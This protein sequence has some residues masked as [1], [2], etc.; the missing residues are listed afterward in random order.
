MQAKRRTKNKQ[1]Q[2]EMSTWCV[3][4]ALNVNSLDDSF[5]MHFVMRNKSFVYFQ[6]KA[7][8]ELIGKII[9]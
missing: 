8:E 5:P 1:Q 3:M 6:K 9:N 7:G 2:H 4:S